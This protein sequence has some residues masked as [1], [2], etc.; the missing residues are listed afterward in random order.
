MRDPSAVGTNR[1]A[2]LAHIDALGLLA[3]AGRALPFVGWASGRATAT[4]GVNIPGM[5]HRNPLIF[6]TAQRHRGGDAERLPEGVVKRI[7]DRLDGQRADGGAFG[8]RDAPGPDDADMHCDGAATNRDEGDGT[9]RKAAPGGVGDGSACQSG[10]AG[11]GGP[12]NGCANASAS[13]GYAADGGTSGLR[14]PPYSGTPTGG[15]RSAEMGA[16]LR[17]TPEPP[18]TPEHP[19]RRKRGGSPGGE[20]EEVLRPV[21]RCLDREPEWDATGEH[22]TGGAGGGRVYLL[23]LFDGVGTAMEPAPS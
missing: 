4:P 14:G 6:D 13:H 20:R 23:S 10:G 3:A 2:A 22:G 16:G 11:H 19:R 21:R 1:Q 5:R 17:R 15:A 7:S 9:G 18:A 8:A 12:A